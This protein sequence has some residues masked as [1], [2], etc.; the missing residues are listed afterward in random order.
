MGGVFSRFRE[1]RLR[2]RRFAPQGH[3]V[4]GRDAEI[5]IGRLLEAGTANTNWRIYDGIRVP[6]P[7]EKRR[8]E[9]DFI[10]VGDKEVWI[11]ELK[12]WSG[13]ISMVG[14]EVKQHRRY[15]S[16]SINHG[17]LFGT[18]AHKANLIS[19]FHKI[20]CGNDGPKM[21]H[22]VVFSNQNLEIPNDIAKR[23]DCL[24][25][26]DLLKMLPSETGI[27]YS[28]DLSEEDESLCASLD[29]LGSWDMV[30]LFGGREFNGDLND[31]DFNSGPLAQ[32]I[33]S[34]RVNISHIVFNTKRS[35]WSILTGN[36]ELT[37][38]IHAKTGGVS[39]C[40]I[41]NEFQWLDIQFQVSRFF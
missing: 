1:V 38:A 14:T 31:I 8:R 2:K 21:R 39:I 11:V 41:P 22:F 18:I 36:F 26:G 35:W 3:E 28:K 19:K 30:R 20:E 13:S 25:E 37:A 24:T 16:E 9:I 4:A 27:K 29:K 32:I 5:R 7:K 33:S 40:E 34:G 10:V 12:H 23:E 6:S 17:D 15:N